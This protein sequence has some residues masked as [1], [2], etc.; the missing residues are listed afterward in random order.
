MPIIR[1]NLLEL[2]KNKMNKYSL[3][4]V[5]FFSSFF[6]KAQSNEKETVSEK[7]QVATMSLN[8]K[9]SAPVLNAYQLNS[10]TKIE[11]LFAYFQLLTD[12]SV[13]NELKKEVVKNINLVFK[14]ENELII[15][16]TSD[17]L[18]K[19]PLQQFLQKLMISEPILFSLSDET[20]FN[21]VDYQSW[22]TGYTIT[23]TKS[24]ITSKIKVIQTVFM[25]ENIKLFGNNQK[26]V[27]QT[28]LGKME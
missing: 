1:F 24:G 9:F 17:S 16:F 14:N 26:L 23:K 13:D 20:K 25:Q 18:D 6:V 12:A 15:D 22:K 11:D 2:N 28:H 10:K 4:V 19:I 7:K 3:V 5:I 8:K 27:Y 21:S